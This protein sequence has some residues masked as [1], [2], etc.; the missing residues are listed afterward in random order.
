MTDSTN[1]NVLADIF[2]GLIPAKSETK[3]KYKHK[4]GEVA[5][6][7]N[8]SI[9]GTKLESIVLRDGRADHMQIVASYAKAAASAQPEVAKTTLDAYWLG[10]L[11]MNFNS[12][13]PA[14][15]KQIDTS[16]MP[17]F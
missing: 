16:D 8:F 6:Y 12:N 7:L 15:K 14:A 1:S 11:G 3:P 13:V 5:G 17:V 10:K 4:D 9:L 2:D